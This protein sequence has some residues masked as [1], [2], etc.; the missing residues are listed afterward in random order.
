MSQNITFTIK[1]KNANDVTK[2]LLFVSKFNA[3]F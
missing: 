2:Q 3:L 1:I